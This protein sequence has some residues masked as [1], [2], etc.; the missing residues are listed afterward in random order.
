MSQSD[1]LTSSLISP[2]PV[3]QTL[4]EFVL[5]CHFD[6]ER[7]AL[8]KVAEAVQALALSLTYLERLK[9][10]VAEAIFNAIAQ[11]R[12]DQP[13]SAVVIRVQVSEKAIRGCSN[14]QGN[15]K[16]GLE[17]E[18]SSLVA[19]LSRQPVL[20]GWGFFLIEKTSN[21]MSSNEV[22]PTIEL[23]LYLEGEDDELP[24]A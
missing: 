15:V 20:R 17:P 11:S 21:S 18:T 6:S 7:L 1:T 9:M 8:I 24:T 2:E 19:E 10:A 4:A 13:D 3:W 23:F 5:P 12:Q 16:L 22:Q 14:G